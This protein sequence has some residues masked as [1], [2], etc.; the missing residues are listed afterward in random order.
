VAARRA[1]DLLVYARRYL[2]QYVEE[3]EGMAEASGLPFLDLL[4]PNCGEEFT[5]PAERTA[6]RLG[7]RR[8]PPGDEAGPGPR[9]AAPGSRSAGP[10]SRRLAAPACTAVAVSVGGRH[11]AGHNMDWYAVDID[12]NVLFDITGPD[13]TRFLTIAGVPYLPIL[14]LNSRGIAYVGN[15]VYSAD[16][17]LG[18]PNVFVRRWVLDAAT[19]TEA[20]ARATL[21]CRARGSNHLLADRGGTLLDIETSAGN[22][23]SLDAEAEPGSGASFCAHTNHYAHPDMI[24]YEG[25]WPRESRERLHRARTLLA[26]GLARGDD[27]V[28]VV[29][30]VLRDHAGGAN[31]ICSHVAEHPPDRSVTVASMICDLDEMRVH[32]CAGPPCEST[33][34]VYTL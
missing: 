13:G 34:Q 8:E 11:I 6:P 30:A 15:S 24:R 20:R 25:Y 21:P 3:L 19:L 31:A 9:P 12:K 23:A 4:V 10:G 16:A 5:C 7:Q 2:P 17:R 32:V 18:V 14:G 28:A 29:A 26:Q 22:A 27:P 1:A 33:Y